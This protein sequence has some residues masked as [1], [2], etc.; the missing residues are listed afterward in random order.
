M[1]RVDTATAFDSGKK[2]RPLRALV[3]QGG[4]ALGAYEAGAFR[5]LYESISET[6]KENALFDIVA[7]TS[8]GAINAAILVSYV[9][10]NDGSWKGSVD[11]LFDFW[12][13]ISNGV[14]DPSAFNIWWDGWW[15][16]LRLINEKIASPEA[17]RRYYTAKLAEYFGV[18]TVFQPAS[19]LV[20]TRY[21]DNFSIPNNWWFRYRPNNLQTMIEKYC[22]FPIKA[23][24]PYPRLLTISTDVLEAV[25]VIFDSYL[26]S[27]KVL[28]SDNS[29]YI[30]DYPEGIQSNHVIASASVPVNYHFVPISDTNNQYHYFWDGGLTS[31]SPLSELLRMHH[32]YY[33]RRIADAKHGVENLSEEDWTKISVPDIKEVYMLNVNP[34]EQQNP[35]ADHDNAISRCLDI[36]L[37]D[38]SS[39]IIGTLTDIQG[40]VDIVKSYR[41]LAISLVNDLFSAD[42]QKITTTLKNYVSAEAYKNIHSSEDRARVDL[43]HETILGRVIS[44]IDLSKEK[45]TQLI[46]SIEKEMKAQ[47][48]ELRSED[49]KTR[50]EEDQYHYSRSLISM[51]DPPQKHHP[52]TLPIYDIERATFRV[53]TIYRIERPYDPNDI[54]GKMF[55]FSKKTVNELIY[56]GYMDA[57]GKDLS[58][59]ERELGISYVTASQ[60]WS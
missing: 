21:L 7:G 38:K 46:N 49:V 45:K 59:L 4:G 11:R 30:L 54:S 27:S 1:M 13:D 37:A 26:L 3:L 60:G 23:K 35:P 55:D 50:S 6:D 56:R 42:A 52:D 9:I 39:I 8:I 40:L 25:P 36:S 43:I 22:Y 15:N 48:A 18:P 20:D 51:F 33:F 5:A 31:N 53:Y 14:L 34:P 10:K 41:E 57:K 44:S 28:K 12:R 24:E 29:T 19:T 32:Y 16:G 58:S 17:A 2:K 47:P